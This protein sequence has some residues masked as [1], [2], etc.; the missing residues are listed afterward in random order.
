[1]FRTSLVFLATLAAV[2]PASASWADLMFQ[3]LSKDFGSVPR[4]PTL[5]HAFHLKNN[6]ADVVHIANVRVSCGCVNASALKYS[7]QPGEET[8]VLANMDTTRFTGVKSVTVYVLFD[9]PHTEEVRLWVRA[10]GRDDVSVYPDTL[11]FGQVKRGS[12]P[13][14][15]VKIT[16]LGIPDARVVE[17]VPESNYIQPTLREVTRQGTEVAYELMPA[18]AAMLRPASGTPTS[19]SRPT[20]RRCRACG[21]R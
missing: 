14:V 21:C 20:T 15:G 16:F 12:S 9:A 2:S 6:T 4:G 10:N 19:G 7:L 11:A 3:E 17:V 18:S 13:S 8:A 1:M 5:Q